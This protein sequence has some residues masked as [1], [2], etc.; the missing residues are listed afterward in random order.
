MTNKDI[1]ELE[2]ELNR[3]KRIRDNIYT[4]QIIFELYSGNT[5]DIEIEYAGKTA[6]IS[7]NL[8]AGM[9]DL[10]QRSIT[11]EQRKLDEME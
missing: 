2:S 10:I 5:G 9:L 6:Y 7:N 11:I 3:A 4:L 1:T 8:K